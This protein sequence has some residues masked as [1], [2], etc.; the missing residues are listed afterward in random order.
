MGD[1]TAALLPAKATIAA[2]EGP[3]AGPAAGR[4]CHRCR[5]SLHADGGWQAGGGVTLK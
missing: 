5:P 1:A 4:E 2:A 3:P